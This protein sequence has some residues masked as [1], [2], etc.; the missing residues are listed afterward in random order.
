MMTKPDPLAALR[1]NIKAGKVKPAPVSSKPSTSTV[2][3]NGIDYEVPPVVAQELGR[4]RTLVQRGA[5]S[6]R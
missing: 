2:M 5:G 1:A 4:L 6:L 3:V